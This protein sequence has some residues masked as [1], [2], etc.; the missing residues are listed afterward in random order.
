MML[1]PPALS[2]T[3]IAEPP[4]IR[5]CVPMTRTGEG[6][7]VG[8][9]ASKEDTAVVMVPTTRLEPSG[10]RETRVPEMVTEGW[11]AATV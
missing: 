9:V 10:S 2:I 1:D 5:V 4:G 6:V 11:P 8:V 7:G 3:V